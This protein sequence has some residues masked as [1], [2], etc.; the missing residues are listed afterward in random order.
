MNYESEFVSITP[1]IPSGKSL[2]EAL[3]FYTSKLGF[4]VV[5]QAGEMAGIQRGTVTLN[6]VQ[7]D[8]KAWIDNSS[9]AIG[10]SDLNAL[11]QEYQT[12]S[13]EVGKLEMKSWGRR[14]FHMIVPS[15]VCLQFYQVV[16]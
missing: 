6:L 5:W 16:D 10:V 7:N 1:I 11:Y 13:V 2:A 14:E 15:G 3:E 4:T 8:D 9:F 12:K